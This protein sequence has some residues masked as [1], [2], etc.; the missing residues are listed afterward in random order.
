MGVKEEGGRKGGKE[1]EKE[2]EWNGW[3]VVRMDRWWN[4][5]DRKEKNCVEEGC[6]GC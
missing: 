2:G 5:R 1:G 6:R 3:M 4:G